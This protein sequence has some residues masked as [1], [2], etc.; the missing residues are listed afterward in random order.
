MKK[1][2]LLKFKKTLLFTMAALTTISA[3]GCSKND[4]KTNTKIVTTEAK[5][6]VT[7]EEYAGGT[8]AQEINTT[9]DNIINEYEEKTNKNIDSSNIFVD[10]FPQINYLWKDKEGNYIYDYRINFNNNQ[11]LEYCNTSTSSKMY[12]VIVKNEDGTY[13]PIAGLV[14]NGGN[15]DNVTITYCYS[16]TPYEPSKDYIIIKNPTDEDLDNLKNGDDYI[17]DNYSSSKENGLTLSKENS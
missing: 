1:I 16:N 2:D 6:E 4:D 9:I 15:V 7:T 8:E 13:E 5:T 3:T 12:A 11:E 17:K 14:K 10:N